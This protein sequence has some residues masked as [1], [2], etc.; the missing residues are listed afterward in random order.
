MV[1][2]WLFA[3]RLK[4]V[5]I[6]DLRCHQ[7]KRD[8]FRQDCVEGLGSRAGQ[9][10]FASP[11]FWRSPARKATSPERPPWEAM[12]YGP[13]LTAS[14]EAPEPRTNIAYKGIAIN[15]GANFG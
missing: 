2:K 7:L 12:D 8:T 15:L 9:P 10:W 14:I 4:V 1:K 3:G 13:Y 11:F 6:I 5:K